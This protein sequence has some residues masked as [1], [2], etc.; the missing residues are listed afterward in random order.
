MSFHLLICCID[1]IYKNVLAENSDLINTKFIG[2]PSKWG[3]PDFDARIL[4]DYCIIE[5]LCN[6]TNAS[7]HDAKNMKDTFKRIIKTFL[8]NNV[9][10]FLFN[11]YF[12]SIDFC[13]YKV[14]VWQ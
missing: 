8:E 12:S 11:F 1:L 7:P 9:S 13:F 6:M 4:K 5:P 14:L 3:K 2:I 10:F